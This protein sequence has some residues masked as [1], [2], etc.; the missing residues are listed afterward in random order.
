MTLAPFGTNAAPLIALLGR[1]SLLGLVLLACAPA[2]ADDHPAPAHGTAGSGYVSPAEVRLRADVGYLAADE[3]GGRGVGTKGIDDAANYLAAILREAGLKP[4]P[5]TGSYFQEFAIRGP[6]R[7]GTPTSLAFETGATKIEAVLGQ[8]F[9]PLAIGTPSTVESIPLVFAGFGITAKDADTNLD[10][11]DYA[12]I[13]TTGKAVLILRRDPDPADKTSVFAAAEPTSYATF[14]SKAINAA[15]HGA[16]LVILVNDHG[17]GSAKDTLLEFDSTPGGG[18]IPFVMIS[19]A[20]ADQILAKCDAPSL[21]D[22]EAKINAELRPVSRELAARV[23]AEVTVTREPIVARNVIGVLEGQGP[24][25]DETIVVGAHYDHLGN[26]GMGSLAFGSREIHNGADDNASGTAT[27]VEMARRFAARPDPLPRRI[28]F[29]LF[30]GEERGLLG[31]EHYVKEPIFPLDKTVSM[32]NFDMVGRFDSGKGLIVYGAG[33]SEGW[34]PLVESLAS[35]LGLNPKLTK[36]A[37][38]EFGDSDHY[39]FYRKDLPVLF[40]FTGTHPDYHRPSDDS[41]KINYAGMARVADLGELVIL[42]IAKRPERPAFV[43]LATPRRENVGQV[44]GNGVYLGTRPAYG[45]DVEGVKL[46]GVSEGSP[47]EKAGLKGGD[48]IIKFGDLKVL[49]IEGYMNAMGT[50]KPGDEVDV[51][52]LR[53]GKEVTLKVKLGTRPSARPSQ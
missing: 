31:S 19:R 26:G 43:K 53:D 8:G 36:G 1:G 18:A 10:Y 42:D 12:G 35:S 28:V 14:T 41:D 21:D 2:R 13:D 22:L 24:L 38:G 45:A 52:V 44:R 11:D 25:A 40:F 39:S 17:T 15:E 7:P 6:A 32:V 29:I 16:K 33:S 9:N 51:V 37:G 47:A 49:S 50:K 4:I 23:S 20:L 48:V 3:R 27:V 34:E 30:S 5:S 46:E